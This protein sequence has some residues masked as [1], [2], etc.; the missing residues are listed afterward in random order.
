[1]EL[2]M[3]VSHD[4]VCLADGLLAQQPAWLDSLHYHDLFRVCLCHPG[5][6]LGPDFLCLDYFYYLIDQ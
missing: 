1:M 5:L 4:A 6:F 2:A 3:R